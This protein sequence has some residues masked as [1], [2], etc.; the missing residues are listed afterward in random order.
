MYKDHTDTNGWCGI[1]MIHDKSTLEL[2]NLSKTSICYDDVTH[3]PQVKAYKSAFLS[4][5]ALAMS[6]LKD[7]QKI[8]KWEL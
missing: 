3:L 8:P 1:T 5:T 6:R 4:S 2:V 7:G